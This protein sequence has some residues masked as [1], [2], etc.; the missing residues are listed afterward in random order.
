MQPKFTKMNLLM[1]RGQ[2]PRDR[3]PQEIVF[4]RM[5]DCDDM[6][7]QL[8]YSMVKPEDTAE[9]WY[10]GGEREHQFSPNF[11]ERWVPS[12]ETYDSD[13]CPDLI[14]CRG[15][16]QEYHHVLRR[17]PF[18]I[19]IYYGAGRRFLPQPGFKDYDVILQDSPEQVEICEQAFPHAL[20]TLFIKPAA[21]NIFYPMEKTKE[22]D[23]CFP[24]N[25]TQSFKGHNFVYATAPKNLK[26][27]NL[28]LPSRVSVPDN[29]TSFRVLRPE[30]AE[31]I[32]RC[33][34][35]IVAVQADID[36]CPRVIP[37]M[38]A[39]GIPIVVL[40]TVRFWK[41]RYIESVVSSRCPYATGETTTR[42]QFWNTVHFVLKNLHLYDPRKYYEQN[43]S[44]V[45]AAQFIR[46]KAYESC[47]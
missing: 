10:W 2:V 37:E 12:F 8:F 27:L 18:A 19:K 42:E 44:L 23:V 40:D 14:F 32:A 41:D 33:K 38:L 3:N 45:Q 20:T 36:S 35:G 30:M 29:V 17:F 22:F 15:G 31:N 26:I 9:L 24:A 25:G 46:D 21:D 11:T 1:L 47:V 13:F 4:D 6:W 7:T 28:G 16:F 43:L 34:V 5:E 39:C